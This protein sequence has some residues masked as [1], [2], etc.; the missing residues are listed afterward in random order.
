M[1]NFFL[2]LS[3]IISSSLSSQVGINTANPNLNSILD[4]VATDKG[5]LFPRL[6]TAQ[7][8]NMSGLGAGDLGMTIFNT[9]TKCYNVWNGTLWYDV[10]GND[11]DGKAEFTFNCSTA[12]ISSHLVVGE[13][14]N[15]VITLEINAT[16]SGTWNIQSNTIDGVS[17]SG[18]GII[19]SPGTQLIRLKAS[20]TPT[21]PNN[22]AVFTFSDTQIPPT[23]CSVTVKIISRSTKTYT[24]LSLLPESWNSAMGSSNS[25]FTSKLRSALASNFSPSGTVKIAGFNY[26]E[27]TATESLTSFINKLNAA[28]IIWCGWPDTNS[29]RL[30][31]DKLQ[32]LKAWIDNKKGVAIIHADD[33]DH[34]IF[35]NILGYA[36]PYY[37]NQS[38]VFTSINGRPLNGSFGDLRSQTLP[39]ASSGA[40]QSAVLGGGNVLATGSGTNVGVPLIILKDNY[41][42]L[43]NIDWAGNSSLTETNT[44]GKLYMNIF[45]WAIKNGPVN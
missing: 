17:Y 36:G 42:I 28:D 34:A 31:N 35:A 2:I 39:L 20:G 32:A 38:G 12:T 40:Y 15:S 29:W 1:K 26:T 24:V 44:F 8:D 19:T 14:A 37:G 43:G 41:I 21:L 25:S 23:N 13:P 16:G 18:A 11:A 7:R 3:F 30:Y 27:A 6:T 33:S 10:C 5:V 9:I 22:G 4:I 45:E